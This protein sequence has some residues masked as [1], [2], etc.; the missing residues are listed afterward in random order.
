M[1]SMLNLPAPLASCGEPCPLSCKKIYHE[2]KKDYE[3]Y[4]ALGPN[5]GIFDQRAAEKAVK[6]VEVMG[7][8]AIA[9]GNVGS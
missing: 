9:F 4:E 7:F 1:T 3:P 5:S 2:H 6:E 8:D